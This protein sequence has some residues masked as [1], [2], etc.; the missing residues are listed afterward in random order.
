MIPVLYEL[1]RALKSKSVIIITA[2]IIVFSLISVLTTVSSGSTPAQQTFSYSYGYGSGGNYTAGVYIVNGYGS[3][4]QG[5]HVNVMIGNMTFS[6]VTSAQGFAL[7]QIR[8][9]SP[10]YDLGEFGGYGVYNYSTYSGQYDNGGG[11]NFYY[12]NSNPY[13]FSELTYSALNL[14]SKKYTNETVNISRY[15]IEQVSVLNNPRISGFDLMYKGN[16]TGTGITGS[17]MVELYYKQ[18][19]ISHTRGFEQPA[20]IYRPM[21]ESNSTFYKSYSGFDTV[22]IIPSNLSDSGSGLYQFGLFTPSGREIVNF[23]E[24]VFTNLGVSSVNA[25]FFSSEMGMMGFFVP[26]MA[27]LAG[28]FTYGKDRT[29][30][31]VESVL[32]R[33]VSRKGLIISRYTA[34]VASVFIATAASLG[35]SSLLFYHFSGVYL[36]EYT[37][38]MA[39]WVLLVEIGAFTGLIYLASGYIKSQGALLGL[40]IALF[41]VFDF[42]WSTSFLP[43]PI[44]PS[45]IL[46]FVLKLNA[47]QVTF[48]RD[49]IILLYASP[50]GYTTLASILVNGSLPSLFI[51]F[52]SFSAIGLSN[53]DLLITG[54]FWIAVPFILALLRFI[55]KD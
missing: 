10:S 50:A 7:V 12:S 30:G 6:G 24:S 39:L 17:P 18:L 21:N 51:Q 4:V 47:G 25:Q 23:T 29:A 31:V 41:F 13:F 42:F 19:N 34:N 28:Y 14:T 43:A 45:A 22:N 36:P 2:L 3:P 40:T 33:P 44:I 9:I 20:Y 26:L 55:R 54:S 5:S 48:L 16:F 53:T 11:L 37:M 27:S 52:T 1:K 32:V 15:S 8:N 49:L 38:L 46:A 35:I